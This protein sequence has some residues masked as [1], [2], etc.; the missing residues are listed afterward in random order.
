MEKH[1]AKNM[2]ISE[3]DKIR[4]HKTQLN[5]GCVACHIIMTLRDNFQRSE[6]DSADILSEVLSDDLKLNEKFIDTVEQIHMVERN[7]GGAFALRERKSKNAYL[8]TYF[9]NVIE[10][11]E[12][13]L[14]HT[15]FKLVIRKLILS[16]V[17]LYLA[18]TLGVDYHAATEELYYLLRKNDQKNEKIDDLISKITS[19]LSRV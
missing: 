7:L 6:Q 18:Q 11:L 13:D 12:S 14:L 1:E 2:I 4:N 16:Y 3:I 5:Q 17:G 10:E 15:E 8:D 19:G 9:K